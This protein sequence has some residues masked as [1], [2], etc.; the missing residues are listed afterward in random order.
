MIPAVMNEPILM[1]E[2]D[3]F[4]LSIKVT[5]SNGDPVDLTDRDICMQLRYGAVSP[6]ALELSTDNGMIVI[7]DNEL[8]L[9]VPNTD[10]KG[11]R[12]EYQFDLQSTYSGIV[13]TILSG[14]VQVIED[15]TY[16]CGG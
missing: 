8:Q 14:R 6:V 1:K 9:T 12:G 10:T 3:T 11:L 15:V 4:N 7:D 5:D 13:E 16:D 2:G